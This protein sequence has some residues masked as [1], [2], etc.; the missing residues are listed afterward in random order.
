MSLWEQIKGG[1]STVFENPVGQASIKTAQTIGGVVLKPFEMLAK[2]EGETLQGNNARQK[3][4]DFILPNEIGGYTSTAAE[5]KRASEKISMGRALAVRVDTVLDKVLGRN[6][7][8]SL[9]PE[10]YDPKTGKIYNVYKDA[11]RDE[12]FGK[13]GLGGNL[14]TGSFDAV[15][16]TIVSPFIVLGAFGKAGRLK[17]LDQKI[18]TERI[19]AKKDLDILTKAEQDRLEYLTA[20]NRLEELDGEDITITGRTAQEVIDERNGL[21]KALPKLETKAN[22]AS[23]NL[24]NIGYANGFDE[25]ARQ[26]VALNA[27]Q[28][29]KHRVVKE[30]S[31]P[32]LLAGLLGETKDV[33]QAGLI[34][35][36][37]AGDIRAQR[38]LAA[39]S[40]ST[41]MA[42]QRAK[43]PLGELT[44]KIKAQK[45]TNGDLH[46]WG[47]LPDNAEI[48]SDEFADLVKRDAFLQRAVKA[49]DEKVLQSRPG[50]S[51]FSTVESFRAAKA[52]TFAELG[53]SS[54]RVWDVE[55][56]RR[57]PFVAT[58]AVVTWPFRERPAGWV[59]NKGINSSGSSK[60]IE[61]FLANT[62]AWEGV[63][64][65]A[66]R[67]QYM[68]QWLSTTDE[69]SREQLGKRIEQDA[70]ISTA[71][72]Y[73]LTKEEAD[74]VYAKLDKER[75]NT[76][77]FFR[78]RGFLIDENN[79]RIY[80][81]QLKTQLADSFPMVD[82]I[83]LDK[84]LS[85]RAKVWAQARAATIDPVVN[86]LDILDEIWRP[87]VLLR[88]GYTQR[89]V[90]EGWGRGT[91][92]LGSLTALWSFGDVL[93]LSKQGGKYDVDGA[94]VRWTKN[95]HAGL[96]DKITV[97]KSIL[98]A[99]RTKLTSQGIPASTLR[100]PPI[101]AA[102][103]DVI[104]LQEDAI[105]INKINIVKLQDELKELKN[106]PTATVQRNSV[107]N[108]L[109]SRRQ[110][111]L[112][113]TAQLRKYAKEAGKKGVKGNRYR[114]GQGFISYGGYD[115]LPLTFEGDFGN[116]LAELSGSQS[117]QAL[118]LSSSNRVYAGVDNGKYRNA[119][120][121]ELQPTDPNYFAGLARVVNRQFR[122]SPTLVRLMRGDSIE[123]V[124]AYLKTQAGRKELRAVRYSDPEEYAVKMQY[125]VERYIPDEALRKRIAQEEVSAAELRVTLQGRD[126]LRSI[127]GDKIQ[128]IPDLTA[129]EK[130]TKAIRGVFRYI[131]A[132]PEDTLIRHPFADKIYQAA[133]KE[134]IDSANR[135]GIR[136]TNSELQGIITGAAR[137]AL[138]ETR[139]TLYTIERYSNIANTVRFLEPF[140]MAAQNTAQVWSKLAYRDPRL[141]GLAGYI[142][143]APDRAGLIQEDPLTGRSV[144]LMQVPDWMRKGPFKDMLANIDSVTF[145]KGGV[146]LIL[147]G[148]D[149]WRI[150]DG[151]FAQ[152]L[153]SE[154]AKKYPTN[155]E[156]IVDYILPRGPSREAFSYDILV[157]TVAK[158]IID[159]AKDTDSRTYASNFAMI[160]QIENNKYNRGL[161]DEPTAE[162][163]KRRT[164]SLS[165]LR[166]LSSFTLGVSLTYRPEMQFYVDKAR[167]YREKYGV[168]AF[169]R[170]YQDFPDYPELFFSLS[171]NPTGMEPTKQAITYFKK[172]PE[173]INKITN[174]QQGFQPEF[175]Q[176][177][178][179]SYGAPTEF[180]QTAYTWQF[181][182]EY[183][184]GS[185][186]LIRQRQSADEVATVNDLQKGWIEWT[187][188]KTSLDGELERRGLTSYNSTGAKD[189]LEL[190]Q[191]FVEQKKGTNPVWWKEYNEGA[192]S[193][194]PY[195]FVKAV[196]IVLNDKKFMAD[197]GEAPLWEAFT[198]YVKARDVMTSILTAKKNSGGS[199]NL[200]AKANKE[201][202]DLWAIKVEQIKTVDPTGAFTT[203][204]NRFLDNDTFEEIK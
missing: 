140:F 13:L 23:E 54:N 108:E 125:A 67:Q 143:N 149:W 36:S 19:V 115:D 135:Q 201:L 101:R 95:R 40:T 165:L 155:W 109:A 60:E 58:V 157:P 37:A 44:E 116:V 66:K 49:A 33:Y 82:I 27:E 171:K 55:Y 166:T 71:K 124:V 91:A 102:W 42:L 183:R 190:K 92:A 96:L 167:L 2:L 25:F 51:L 111:E 121:S 164:D 16:G 43:Q 98:E 153:V 45:Q 187:K 178:T 72:K 199:G 39:E 181:L 122:N 127:H 41:F 18:T 68:R 62:K 32:E 74:E 69:I 28:L 196:K 85:Q 21:Q 162:E 204:Y 147:Q 146:N 186:E 133:L 79:E 151:P 64:G 100:M 77:K 104:K 22:K 170:F 114:R 87:A 141:F 103:D 176:L 1:I 80:V 29:L 172:Y 56:F 12:R 193:K 142:Y 76:I 194:R 34:I 152:V 38:L 14:I 5:R 35:R 110:F 197:R 8:S 97:R 112:E 202:A 6:I 89:N 73:G 188:F 118:E 123:S 107:I 106:D 52:R 78:E 7:L 47:L 184:T 70:I 105:T 200:D 53:S 88:L 163:I 128:E 117:R 129:Y 11:K 83:K 169:T 3:V 10:S 203:Y 17:T 132:L 99:E 48:L 189:L 84:V 182:N 30:S 119:G 160:K 174:P 24:A 139:R 4:S 113:A 185:N 192:G 154:F 180:D 175:L 46:E 161:R 168:D 158:R 198:E 130:Y 148:Q 59:P 50:T 94:L 136:L 131:G 150:G 57:N 137:K 156:S 120:F 134:S 179:N 65:Q 177:I 20:K 138:Q 75:G 126:D 15:A 26:A 195:F 31:D 9:Q 159:S 90:A 173:L 61:A 145:E 86:K 63:E 191:L 144:V 81:P 93:K